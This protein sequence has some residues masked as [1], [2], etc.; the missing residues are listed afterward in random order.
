MAAEYILCIVLG[1]LGGMVFTLIAGF[2]IIKKL[3]NFKISN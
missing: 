3:I 1:F 2:C